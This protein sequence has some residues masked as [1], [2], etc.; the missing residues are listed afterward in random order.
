[1]ATEQS[2][3][4]LFLAQELGV[5]D[6]ASA[7]ARLAQ[8][9][10]V[11]ALAPDLAT[12][13]LAQLTL[14]TAANILCRLGPYCPTIALAL[15][16]GARVADGVPLV[17]PGRPLLSA[18]SRFM[19]GVHQPDARA[20]YRYRAAAPDDKF[21]IA[22][23]V[24]AV[25]V[26]ARRA[27]ACW[28]ERWTGGFADTPHPIGYRGPNPFGALLAGALGAAAVSRLL[29][30]RVADPASAPQPLPASAALSAYS[31]EQPERP[32][33]EPEIPVLIDLRLLQSALLVG[34]GAVGAGLAFALASLDRVVGSLDAADHDVL[35]ATNLERH[36]ISTWD[37]VGI[38]KVT[39]LADL[40][41]DGAWNGLRLRAHARRYEELP[42]ASWRTVIAAADGPESR[43]RLQFDLPRV[44]LN[45][46]TVGPELLV[47]RH[48]YGPGPCAECLYPERPRAVY[49]P[50]ELLAEQ[51]GL[52]VDE[53][54]ELQAMGVP[55]TAEQVERVRN[56]GALTFPPEVY[57]RAGHDGIRALA[58][59]ACTTATVR[60]GLP[61]ATIGFVAA[62]PGL[63]LAGELVKEAMLRARGGDWPPLV[64]L[65]NVFR[66]DTFGTLAEGLE[67]ARPSRGCR[68]QGRV[69]RAA[70]ARRWAGGV[71]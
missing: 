25:S 56:R 13:R 2:R 37:H 52:T 32:E 45:A 41:A 27:V 44:L 65:R 55:L 40:F 50:I 63:L 69:M 9:A 8:S 10:V 59:A 66:F 36:L 26:P 18:L 53:V 17:E 21:D 22:L 57:R 1:M 12:D 11:L 16:D 47:S 71:L 35:D 48:D 24:G 34:A 58:E 60:P 62:L 14:L 61:V 38:P 28:Y 43:R 3:A 49:S 68:C 51:T 29:L 33:D 6:L 46:G 64:G 15:P 23:T 5:R 19:A 67:P 39:R 7:R 4:E 20:Q 42:P 70:Y 31:Y 54:W 30:A